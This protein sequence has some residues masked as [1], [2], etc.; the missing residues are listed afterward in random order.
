[1]IEL[2]LI[3][4]LLLLLTLITTEFG[5]AVHQYNSI[6]KSVRDAVRYLSVQTPGTHTTEAQNLVVFGNTAG[7]GTP[8]VPG[9]AAATHVPV[10]TWQAVGTNPVIN[11]VTVTVTGYTFQPLFGNVFGVAFGNFTYSDITATMRAPGP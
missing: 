8:L 11:T 2:A 9:L 10:P 4:P 7:M 3:L 6:A 1:M 5:R